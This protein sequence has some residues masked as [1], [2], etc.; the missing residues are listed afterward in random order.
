M[1]KVKGM[2]ETVDSVKKIPNALQ[3]HEEKNS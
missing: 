2:P 3:G 1:K